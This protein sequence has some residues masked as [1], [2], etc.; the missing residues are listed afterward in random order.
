MQI[1]CRTTTAIEIGEKESKDDFNSNRVKCECPP[2]I[3]V[4]PIKRG[5]NGND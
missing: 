5:E 1:A 4:N 3:G 2:I